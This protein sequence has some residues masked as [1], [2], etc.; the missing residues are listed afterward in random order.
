MIDHYELLQI[1]PK[2]DGETIHRVYRYLAAR[3]HPDNAKTGDAAK[4][5]L[6]KTAYDVLSHPLRRTEYDLK[7]SKLPPQVRQP[8]SATID[9]MDQFDG[10]TNRRMAVLGVLYHHR[11][12]HPNH[13]D[14]SL[15][16]IEERMG[17]PRDF[18]DFTLWYLVK[19][20]YAERTDSV[21]YSL[22]A[23]GVDFV[24]RERTSAP[25]LNGL[26]TSSSSPLNSNVE[27]VEEDARTV[28]EVPRQD[29][30][31][32]PETTPKPEAD[33][34]PETDTKPGP[35]AALELAKDSAV[36]EVPA[37]YSGGPI[38]LPSNMSETK[39]RRNGKKDRRTNEPDLRIIKL[40]R[41]KAARDR[42]AG[43]VSKEA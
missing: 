8:L 1:S 12:A 7:R 5:R 2:A 16:E 6:V 28:A 11:R 20:R 23:E 25:V 22:T 34:T 15:G 14:V 27:A 33:T 38:M 24:E 41:R 10:E 4:F 42:R 29:A 18:L 40:E 32:K 26:L 9:F 17:F 30:P 31:P 3:L 19:K 37:A 21:T 36:S 35:T 43:A 39:E 13:P